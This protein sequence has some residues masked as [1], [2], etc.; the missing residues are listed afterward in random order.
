[1]HNTVTTEWP[2]KKP[3]RSG[4]ATRARLTT[5]PIV[6]YSAITPSTLTVIHLK[7]PDRTRVAPSP[8]NAAQ[9]KITAA[10]RAATANVA[11]GVGNSASTRISVGAGPA[12]AT[13]KPTMP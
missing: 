6:L 1:A 5:I 11:S 12:R 10:A 3:V 9:H 13:A 8:M 4:D 2:V 7:R